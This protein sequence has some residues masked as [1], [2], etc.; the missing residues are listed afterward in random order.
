MKHSL[1]KHA[2]IH[3]VT[4]MLAASKK[5]QFPGRNHLLTT[6]TDNPSKYLKVSSS[7]VLGR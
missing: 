7:L 4:T 5:A 2:T 3:K 1:C 6:G